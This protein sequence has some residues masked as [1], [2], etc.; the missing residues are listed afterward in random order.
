MTHCSLVM[1]IQWLFYTMAENYTHAS[2]SL[3]FLY[4]RQVVD[5]FGKMSFR[6]K[7]RSSK[8]AFGKKSFRQ[9][10]RRQS[11]RSAK[12]LSAKCPGTPPP[13]PC[14]NQCMHPQGNTNRSHSISSMGNIAED[15]DKVKLHGQGNIRS[16][17]MHSEGVR[18]LLLA[19][20]LLFLPMPMH[21]SR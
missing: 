6:R 3:K 20:R 16:R 13:R 5:P 17:S 12:R 18:Y 14:R 7:V 21:F 8:C 9:I 15:Y 4:F 1:T 11:V 19:I 10:V 2:H